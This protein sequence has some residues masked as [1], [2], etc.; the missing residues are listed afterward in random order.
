MYRRSAVVEDLAEGGLADN[1]R[2]GL[3]HP[4]C[5]QHEDLESAGTTAR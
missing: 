2:V 4:L 3:V 5:Q 1:N